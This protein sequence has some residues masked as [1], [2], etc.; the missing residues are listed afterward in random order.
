M[1]RAESCS[2]AMFSSSP[3]S[4]AV[5]ST[6]ARMLKRRDCSTS[7]RPAARANG[8]SGR[9]AAPRRAPAAF[10]P[11]GGCVIAATSPLASK[12][13]TNMASR[14]NGF[15]S[16][17][18]TSSVSTSRPM[19][20]RRSTIALRTIRLRSSSTNTRMRGRVRFSPRQHR[21]EQQGRQQE[22]HRHGDRALGT[23]G[24]ALQALAH[25][26]GVG[27]QLACVLVELQPGG[28]GG[29]AHVGSARRAGCRARPRAS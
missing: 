12:P 17:P 15:T 19:S 3:R 14:A 29:D 10:L 22:G 2:W 6:C 16:R 8:R 23:F 21:A 1:T 24:R 13:Q 9:A 28:R 18:L 4:V 20:A 25:G 27:Q 7:G 11:A 5:S 26:A